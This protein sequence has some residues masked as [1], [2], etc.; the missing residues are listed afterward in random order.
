[1]LRRVGSR[2]GIVATVVAAAALAAVAVG[3]ASRPLAPAS[4]K[5]V[6]AA[7]AP[8]ELGERYIVVLKSGR[9]PETVSRRHGLSPTHSYSHAIRGFAGRLTAA[10]R[11]RLAADADVDYIEKDLVAHT[12]AQTLPTGV[13]RINADLT[14]Q[15]GIDGVDQRVDVDIAIIDSGIDL[16]HPDLNVYYNQNFIDSADDGDDDN[17][18]GSHVAGIA[19][20]LD[21]G[22]GS[23]G[24]A[25]GA[26]L[27]ALKVLDSNGDGYFS[28]IIEAVDFVT[29]HAADIEVVNMSLSG[30]GQMSSFRSA[31]QNSVAAGVVYVVAAGN[32]GINVYGPDRK[33][34]TRDDVIPASY[35]EV[36]T[37]SAIVDTDGRAGALGSTTSYG[38]DDTFAS[39][40]NYSTTV[41]AGN[42]V[43]SPG[44]AIDV[45]APGVNI[46]STYKNGGYST[47]SGTS[48]AAPHVA[49]AVALYIAA[50]GRPT[51]AAGV[52][53]VRQ[54]I[55]N[56]AEPQSAWGSSETNDP[57]SKHEG[58]VDLTPG[59]ITAWMIVT[60]HG[61]TTLDV[62]C[63]NGDIHPLTAGLTQF[64]VTFDKAC[65]PSS[66]TPAAIGVVGLTHGNQ[67]SLVQSVVAG[68]GNLSALI[69]LAAPPD[70]D[71][72]TLT[73]TGFRTA[74]GMPYTGA[75]SLALGCLAGDADGTGKVTGTD[76]TAVRAR[77]GQ[78]VTANTARY[79]LDG[80]GTIDAADILA[81]RA[82]AGAALP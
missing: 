8:A 34:N 45:A 71:I 48:M 70:A 78:T 3:S 69:T 30:E 20:A 74:G 52:Y 51:N 31:I 56:G 55:I 28:D 46:Y 26:R 9:Q 60:T 66:L 82:H 10:Q 62:P 35:P 54:A 24:V 6:K 40:T 22:L 18:H 42:P 23:V 37:V 16:D 47:I 49:G 15:A 59:N 61:D 33:F 76:L 80:S 64:R 1:M 65:L 5:P 25:P 32:D 68:A 53:A 43:T 12:C 81:A 57:D 27:W 2:A 41:T 38:D 14:P 17:G 63:E 29:A 39:F 77:L 21:N 75:T 73:L 13:N 4:N 7:A 36:M 50:N 44:A 72:Y 67:S 11:T 58:L 79:D 19:A